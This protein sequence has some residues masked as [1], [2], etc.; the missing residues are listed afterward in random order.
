MD[1]GNVLTAMVTPFDKSGKMDL[2]QTTILIEYLL[3]NGTDGLV[4]NGT[5]GESPTLS[6]EEKIDLFKHVVKIVNKRV[7]VIAGTTSNDTYASIGLTKEAEKVGV[8][9]VMLVAPY[10]NKPTQR[11]MYEHFK[12]IAKETSLPVVLYNIPGRSVVNIDADTII[13]LSKIDN[14]VSVKEA[15][16]DLDLASKVIEN[17]SDDFSVYSGEDGL[18]IPMLAIGGDGVISVASHIIGNEMQNMVKK[19]Q[20]GDVKEAASLHRQLLP[21]MRGIFKQPS[22]APVKA[23]LQMKGVDTGG[24]RLPLLDLTEQEA[25]DLKGIIEG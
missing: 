8:D 9:A 13:D 12:A 14:I 23:A 10:Y 1:F 21:I 15:S 6:I 20:Q 2:E 11:G 7:P 4:I 19:Y 16:G 17:T 5:T 3:D 24:V 18:T 22:P 25:I